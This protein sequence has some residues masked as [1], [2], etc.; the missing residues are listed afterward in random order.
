MGS[1]FTPLA[2]VT[3]VPMAGMSCEHAPVDAHRRSDIVGADDIST[4]VE[5]EVCGYQFRIGLVEL[6]SCIGG[7]TGMV[8]VHLV[9]GAVIRAGREVARGA[10]LH[11]IA[12]HLHVPEQGLAQR[13]GCV[14][15]CPLFRKGIPT[16]VIVLIRRRQ[17]RR[18]A[19]TELGQVRR[20]VLQVVRL[21]IGRIADR[22]FQEPV[23]SPASISGRC[24]TAGQCCV[25][26]VAAGRVVET[27]ACDGRRW[28]GHSGNG[29]DGIPL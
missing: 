14:G 27:L 3:K 24:T 25:A 17:G 29:R 16:V 4:G 13:S 28:I 7:G 23:D 18:A 21:S 8:G 10:G 26:I 20:R 5:R 22:R 11:A 6:E 2:L 15:S 1:T 12:A 9:L 19:Q